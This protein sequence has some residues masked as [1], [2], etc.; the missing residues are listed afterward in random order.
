MI[1]RTL[2]PVNVR[3]LKDGEAKAALPRRLETYMDE[4][5]L[6]PSGLPDPDLPPLDGRTSIP[7]HL[8]LDVLVDRTLVPRGMPAK[9][10][11]RFQPITESV[12]IA[13]LDSR[14]VVPAYVEPAA[15]EA[16][17]EFQHAP[18]MT[19]DLREVIE[20][21][22][23]ITGDPNL[24]IQPDT[25]KDPK[26]DALMRVLSVV[27]HVAVIAFVLLWPK[28]FPYHGPTQE[29][30]DLAKQALNF[31]YMPPE[32]P[33]P[34]APTPKLNMNREI[35]K[36]V[37]PELKP[38][39]PAPAPT[40]ERPPS[41]LPEAPKPRI[42]VAPTPAAPSQPMAPAPSHLEPVVPATPA[43]PN[44][45]NL[46]L[47][48]SSPGKMIQDQLGDAISR[49][50]KQGGVYSGGPAMPGSRGGPGMG[51]GVTILSD[52]QG[53]DFNPYIQRLLATL[54]RNWYYIMPESAL[55]GDRGIVSTT[56]QINPD[57]SVPPPDPLLERTSGKGPLD[58]AAMSAIHASNPFEPLPSAFHG[59]YLKLRIIFLYNITPEQAGLH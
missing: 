46:Q 5:T 24:L 31:V 45:L 26:W 43:N 18:E 3:P 33:V 32:K 7:S 8:P 47:P 10:I 53:V 39:I 56:F 51:Y 16:I 54:K 42:Q 55:M 58:N 52:T 50:P 59:P 20:P 22:M 21:D 12:P 41:D 30:V 29:D 14:V 13:V 49:A 48:Q 35:L 11:E 34:P 36:S 25:K 19:A 37:V 6:V 1:P 17:K 15:P 2:V 44:H 4:R 27:V 57:G 28:I 38:E 40:P 9:P 23:F